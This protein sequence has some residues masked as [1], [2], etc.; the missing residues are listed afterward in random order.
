M[1]GFTHDAAS[2]GA[3]WLPESAVDGITDAATARAATQT[4]QRTFR[5]GEEFGTEAVQACSTRAF[6]DSAAGPCR[7][8]YCA[9]VTQTTDSSAAFDELSREQVEGF[10]DKFLAAWNSHDPSQLV[11]L[12][13]AD[14]L[15]EDPY[16][17]GGRLVG[18]Q[19][20]SDW[21]S[22]VWRSMPDLTF[23]IVGSLHLALDQRSAMVNWRGVGTM[24]GELRPPGFAPTNG[25]V[26]M[27]GADTHW[28]RDGK[29]AHVLTVT[30]VMAVGRQI[31]AAPQPGSRAERMGIVM[32]RL[33]A[34]KMRKSASA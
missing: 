10:A 17:E 16:I 11:A 27:L 28:M 26:E 34:R 5:T 6:A 9:L 24:T 22:S 30:D 20:L 32:Q 19:A 14:V 15:W 21:L 7:N 29:L 12:S 18:H 33:A 31:G 25:R 13:T 1:K 8:P 3:S 4:T 2:P 23:E